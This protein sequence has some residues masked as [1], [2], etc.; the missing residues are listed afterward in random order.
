MRCGS[1]DRI[2]FRVFTGSFSREGTI[3]GGLIETL[4]AARE[5]A[6][7]RG[8]QSLNLAT[9]ILMN[10]FYG[11]LGTPACR[12]YDPKLAASITR[13][14]HEIMLRTRD[15]IEQ[16][17]HP[18]IYGDTD[19]LF[20]AL[21]GGYSEA[22]ALARGRELAPA[23]N[24]WWRE[25]IA[26][27]FRVPSFLGLEFGACCRNSMP[28]IR[29]SSR[30][31]EAVRGAAAGFGRTLDMTFRGLES[32]RSD[33]TPLARNF[34]QALYRRCLSGAVG[35]LR[36]PD[37]ADLLAGRLTAAGTASATAGARN[38]R[39]TSRRSRQ[40]ARSGVFG[41][42]VHYVITVHGPSLHPVREPDRLRA[43]SDHQL[44][45]VADDPGFQVSFARWRIRS[46]G[47]RS[48]VFVFLRSHRECLWHTW[49]R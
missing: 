16:E 22:S 3:L 5:E 7:R 34:Q 41:G 24:A 13:R 4:W 26:R 25:I 23:I 37:G 30:D 49:G 2:R 33:W 32:V 40:R 36:L 27:E 35:G 17:G 10:A 43:L 8:D 28:T 48:R 14:S 9:K 6:K 11:V 39:E 18:V 1:R 29:G 15:R 47:F 46:S 38:T 31:E 19:S 21:G 20:V 12:F 42:V 44:A 45:P